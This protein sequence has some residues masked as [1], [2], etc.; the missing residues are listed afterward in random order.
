MAIAVIAVAISA[1]VAVAVA[2]LPDD[3][4]GEVERISADGVAPVLLLLLS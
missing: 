2:L 4:W 1:V 3:F